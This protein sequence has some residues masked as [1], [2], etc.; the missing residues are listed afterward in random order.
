MPAN[1]VDHDDILVT[2][3]DGGSVRMDSVEDIIVDLGNGGVTVNYTTPMT[4]TALDNTTVTVHGGSGDDTLDLTGRGTGGSVDSGDQH[5]VVYDGGANGA[6]GDTVILDFNLSD[7]TA[8]VKETSG[9]Q[10]IGFDTTVRG[11]DA[12]VTAI[13]P[14]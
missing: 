2:M 1:G 8:V 12:E 10:T 9:G 11:M 5:H 6:A 7:V 4:G 14:K 13:R 3:S